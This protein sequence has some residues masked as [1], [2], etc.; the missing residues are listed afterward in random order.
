MRH[1][2]HNSCCF[3]CD[4]LSNARDV[5]WDLSFS[6]LPPFGKQP[7]PSQDAPTPA[8]D[9][10]N[11]SDIRVEIQLSQMQD[12][13]VILHTLRPLWPLSNYPSCSLGCYKTHQGLRAP[14]TVRIGLCSAVHQNSLHALLQALPLSL[15]LPSHLQV[16]EF[17]SQNPLLTQDTVLERQDET[18]RPLTSLKW[19]YVPEE[20][21]YLDPLKRDDPKVVQLPQYEAIGD[22]PLSISDNNRYKLRPLSATSV[23]VRKA[24]SEH[25][26]LKPLLR[27]I[28]SL[29]GREREE[30]LQSALG[31]SQTNHQGDSGTKKLGI[32]KED[33]EAMRRLSSAIETAIRGDRPSALGLDIDGEP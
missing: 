2:T 11:L 33:I 8:S 5:H 26:D 15:G 6:C 18:L 21:A 28:D 25:Q 16:R 7:L 32:G 14:W 27:S 13:L 4:N 31:V 30:A 10:P 12:P 22:S 19:P 17:P 9:V 23:A 29:R 24:L 1:R 3:C 20:S